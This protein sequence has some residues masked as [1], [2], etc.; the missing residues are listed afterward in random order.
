VKIDIC[1]WLIKKEAS[2]KSVS[3][4]SGVGN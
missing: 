1:K 4:V 2:I 3:K